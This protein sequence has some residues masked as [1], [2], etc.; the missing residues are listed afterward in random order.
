MKKCMKNGQHKGKVKCRWYIELPTEPV[1]TNQF[2]Y[3]QK[4]EVFSPRKLG[5]LLKKLCNEIKCF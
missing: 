4:D 1:R 5:N 3:S 2:T